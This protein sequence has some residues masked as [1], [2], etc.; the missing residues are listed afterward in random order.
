MLP[1]TANPAHSDLVA[2]F[3]EAKKLGRL[4]RDKLLDLTVVTREYRNAWIRYQVIHNRRNDILASVLLGY[5]VVPGLHFPII[6][7]QAKHM[8]SLVLA[9]RGAGKTTVGTIVDAIGNILRYPNVRILIASKTLA[10]AM[11]FLKEIKGHFE[12]NENFREVF[13]DWVGRKQWDERSIEINRRKSNAK[14]PTI[15]T[16]GVDGAVASKHY[17][18]LYPD[19]LVEEENSRTEHMRNK[20]KNWYYGVLLPCL[21]PAD[22]SIPVRGQ[23]RISGT[24]YHPED[25]YNHL[26]HNEFRDSILVIP[27]ISPEDKSTWPVKFPIEFLREKRQNMG[28]V[29]FNAQFQCDCEAMKGEIFHY[30]HFEQHYDFE[31]PKPETCRI[32]MGVDLAIGEKESN[33]MFAWLVMGVKDDHYWIFDYEESRLRFNIQTNHILEYYKKY[34]PIW[35]AV[36]SNA[37]QMAQLHNLKDRDPNFRGLR[38]QT[39]KDK[40]TRA[41]KLTPHFESGKV[42]F[43]R[44]QT[45]LMD[46]LVT[47]SST[48]KKHWDLFDALDLAF[49]AAH[50]R[51]RKPRKSL[52]LI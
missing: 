46:R 20:L 49:S 24:R 13:G 42:H 37:Y 16:V 48:I 47:R 3:R 34:D 17:D 25:L 39:I 22:Q 15:M 41:W 18:V 11:D 2:L 1:A 4:P 14:E 19:D 26:Q 10:N 50:R 28:M 30:D 33:D 52:G 23:L 51:Q 12:S 7:H 21:E 32:Y 5:E 35:C 45:L 9:F 36:E 8:H 29:L 27:A 6:S 31:F 38:V 44:S 43:K 40:V